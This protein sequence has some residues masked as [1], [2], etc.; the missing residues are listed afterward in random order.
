LDFD[1]G[2]QDGGHGA[3]FEAGR[4]FDGADVLYGLYD[5]VDLALCSFWMRDLS[6]SEAD[7]DL[8]LVALFT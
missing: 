4:G 8:H 7:G 1:S 2:G 6:A 3:A 5:R